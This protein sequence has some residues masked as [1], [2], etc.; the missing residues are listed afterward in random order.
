MKD[1]PRGLRPTIKLLIAAA[2]FCA[3][4]LSGIVGRDALIEP[5]LGIVSL[6]LV[7]SGEATFLTCALNQGKDW[8]C[9]PGT[10]IDKPAPEILRITVAWEKTFRGQIEAAKRRFVLKAL[11]ECRDNSVEGGYYSPEDL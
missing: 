4:A 11:K 9:G 2:I 5:D 1:D 3:G 8:I 10:S 7:H 6:R